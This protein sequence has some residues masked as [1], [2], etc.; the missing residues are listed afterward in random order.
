MYGRY[1]VGNVTNKEVRMWLSNVSVN[2]LTNNVNNTV[3]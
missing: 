1:V 3:D 2:Y